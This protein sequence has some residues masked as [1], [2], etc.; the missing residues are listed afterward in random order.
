MMHVLLEDKI[1]ASFMLPA[2]FF[3]TASRASAGGI[4]F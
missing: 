2:N 1:I 3:E 4:S